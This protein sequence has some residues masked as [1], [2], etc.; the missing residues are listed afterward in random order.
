MLQEFKYT[1]MKHISIDYMQRNY[2]NLC[3]EGVIKERTSRRVFS[4]N[5][6][7]GVAWRLHCQIWQFQTSSLVVVP[8]RAAGSAQRPPV[9]G[10][11]NSP[12]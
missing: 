8:R 3:V 1:I 4:H 6:D 9:Q 7:L 5:P 12:I 10:K 11:Y 2:T